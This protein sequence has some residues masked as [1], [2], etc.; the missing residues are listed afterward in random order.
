MRERLEVLDQVVVGDGR[1]FDAVAHDRHR[2]L[3]QS[4]RGRVQL[5]PPRRRE[6]VI[7][8]RA[9]QRVREL[10]QPAGP[11]QPGRDR[12]VERHEFGLRQFEHHAQR[13]AHAERRRGLEQADDIRLAALQPALDEL[14]VRAGRGQR[15][16]LVEPVA[17]VGR[18]AQHGARVQRVAPG[19][20]VEATS[21]LRRHRHAEL[22][23]EHGD[24]LAGQRAERHR[25]REFAPALGQG[26]VADRQQDQDRALREPAGREQQRAERVGVGQVS[27]VD[28]HHAP[29]IAR[30]RRHRLQ[31]L[32]AHGD[33]L[34]GT[35]RAPAARPEQLIR[36]CEAHVGLG[37]VT[38]RAQSRNPF[39]FAQ[40]ALH[41]RALPDAGLAFD[42]D[43]SRTL[44]A[45][46]VEGRAQRGELILAT[47]EDVVHDSER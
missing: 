25:W 31:Q 47:D 21:G 30:G 26:V 20:L 19:V 28:D 27:V 45:D 6:R 41:Q 39:E 18:L 17:G 8:R 11:D 3:D 38:A 35:D 44:A 29:V 12:L 36:E 10:D 22:S 15:A 32:H 9:R 33:V 13:R 23:P 40:K 5:G 42:D 43:R 46:V 24:V 16:R 14:C 1:R 4:R 2:V 34:R 7:D 37:L